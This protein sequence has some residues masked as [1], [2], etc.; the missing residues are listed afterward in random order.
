MLEAA[1]GSDY[2]LAASLG[3]IAKQL[4]ALPWPEING[5]VRTVRDFTDSSPD[6]V[7]AVLKVKQG[8]LCFWKQKRTV[9]NW[10]S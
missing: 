9:L 3:R 7:R 4:A 2:P 8:S 1:S 10:Q 6:R 5:T